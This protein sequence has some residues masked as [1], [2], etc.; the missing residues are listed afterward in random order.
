ML[1]PEF[2][3]V[4]Q[5]GFL[6]VD[7]LVGIYDA[8]AGV[9]GEIR[10]A[11]TKVF[12]QSSCA[13]CDLTHGWRPWGSPQWRDACASAELDLQLLHRDQ[14]SP[15]QLEAAG[16]LPAFIAQGA[17]GWVAVMNAATIASFAGQPHRLVERLAL[18]S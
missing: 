2:D 1:A 6:L 17:D 4:G 5:V 14:A 15:E 18:R 12:G 13:L 11:L 7:Q 3:R 9:T 10:Y 8:D 16:E